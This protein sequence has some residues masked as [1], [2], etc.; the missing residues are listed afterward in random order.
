MAV[1]NEG[2]GGESIRGGS[3]FAALGVS[4]AET[5]MWAGTVFAVVGGCSDCS[6]IQTVGLGTVAPGIESRGNYAEIAVQRL[7]SQ[8]GVVSSHVRS[9]SSTLLNSTSPKCP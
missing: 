6:S 3:C 9:S 2:V 4:A 1:V 7:V 8:L 5:K